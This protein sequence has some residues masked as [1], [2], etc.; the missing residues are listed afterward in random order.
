ML[1]VI[2]LVGLTSHNGSFPVERERLTLENYEG[3]Y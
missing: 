2:F 3:G 1:L